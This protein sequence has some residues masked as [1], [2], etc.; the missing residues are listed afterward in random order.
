MKQMISVKQ[1]FLS[2]SQFARCT[3]RIEYKIY[4]LKH[5]S[6]FSGQ[7]VLSVNAVFCFLLHADR[8]S[9]HQSSISHQRYLESVFTMRKLES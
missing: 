8:S 4:F 9:P 6:H 5:F 3:L 2:Y 7:Q 1:Q